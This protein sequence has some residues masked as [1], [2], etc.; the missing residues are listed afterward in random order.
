M[1]LTFKELI[2]L[3]DLIF[4]YV[5]LGKKTRQNMSKIQ[6][7]QGKASKGQIDKLNRKFKSYSQFY[8]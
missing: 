8:K 1:A 5:V 2:K 4:Q 6:K 3:D 7:L